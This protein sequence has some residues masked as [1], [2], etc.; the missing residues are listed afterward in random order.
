MEKK[1][2]LFYV[3]GEA[4]IA[5]AGE[6]ASGNLGAGGAGGGNL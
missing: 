1:K 4:F 5:L 2:N 6:A 3:K